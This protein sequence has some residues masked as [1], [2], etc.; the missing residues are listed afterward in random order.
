MPI[1]L[2]GPAAVSLL[3]GG[4]EQAKH[5]A[6]TSKV[7]QHLLQPEIDRLL[8]TLTQSALAAEKED[9]PGD[10]DIEVP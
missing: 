1:G 10:A 2:A 9:V 8:A 6:R 5:C 4:L 3:D 7:P